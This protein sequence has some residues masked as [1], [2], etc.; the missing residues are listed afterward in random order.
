MLNLNSFFK[1]QYVPDR[2]GAHFV[3]MQNFKF[4]VNIPGIYKRHFVCGDKNLVFT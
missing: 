2:R 1:W 4:F 3:P